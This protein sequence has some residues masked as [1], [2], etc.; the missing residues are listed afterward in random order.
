MPT[1]KEALAQITKQ[2]IALLDKQKILT[3]AESKSLFEHFKI[4]P[5]KVVYGLKTFAAPPYKEGKL[6]EY[7]ISE[8]R[9]LTQASKGMAQVWN[10]RATPPA[11]EHARNRLSTGI[12][13]DPVFLEELTNLLTLA[14][15][16]IGE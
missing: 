4:T 8:G 3:T 2:V 1:V 13:E 5:D 12:A 6:T 15:K 11:V 10:A 14:L 9:K 7:V 16:I